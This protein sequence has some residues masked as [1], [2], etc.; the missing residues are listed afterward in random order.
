MLPNPLALVLLSG[1]IF[2]AV[3]GA[4][5]WAAASPFPADEPSDG[6]A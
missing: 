4:P 3:A 2:P 6:P 5:A 1:T